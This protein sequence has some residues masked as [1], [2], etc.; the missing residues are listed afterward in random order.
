MNTTKNFFLFIVVHVVSHAGYTSQIGQ[1]RYLNEHYFNN[2]KNGVFVDIGAYDGLDHSN[3]YFFEKELGWKGICIEPHPDVFKKL[4]THRSCICINACV[5]P[6]EGTVEF[7]KVDGTP[8]MLSG[9]KST[10]DPRHLRRLEREILRDG[11]SCDIID[12][13][14]VTVNSVLKEYG[15]YEIDYLSLDTEGGELEILNSIDFDMFKIFAI[16]VENNFGDPAIR[17]LL[18]SKGF[19]FIT[20]LAHQDE[21]YI[22]SIY[23]YIRL[24]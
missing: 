2:K 10:Y 24:Q 19:M 3:T 17:N 20:L 9:M 14:G 1:D 22:N 6:S 21:V 4:C 13:S 16:T 8:T 11:G 5:A 12:I 23:P 15:I 18:E 7:I